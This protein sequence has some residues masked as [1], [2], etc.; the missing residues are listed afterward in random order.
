MHTLSQEEMDG[1]VGGVD[2]DKDCKCDALAVVT[3]G[4]CYAGLAY[5]CLLG[6][7]GHIVYC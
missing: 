3:A 7:A 2:C 5:A 4:S 1:V 6:T